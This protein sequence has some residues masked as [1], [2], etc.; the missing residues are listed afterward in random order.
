MEKV[1]LRKLEKV[2]TLTLIAKPA[3]VLGDKLEELYKCGWFL[4]KKVTVF[5]GGASFGDLIE[6]T[7]RDDNL[8]K[9]CMLTSNTITTCTKC[10]KIY[11]K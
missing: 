2:D 9:E 6:Y 10:R 7:L 4:C 1:I 11:N 3:L 5:F 8:K